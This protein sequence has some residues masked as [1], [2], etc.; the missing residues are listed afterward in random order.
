MTKFV[1]CQPDAYTEFQIPCHLRRLPARTVCVAYN[2]VVNHSEIKPGDR[3]VVLGPGHIGQLS[4]AIAKLWGAKVAVA[5]L[6][7]DSKRL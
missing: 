6:E 2:E 5:G 7:S 3:V 1:R 4:A